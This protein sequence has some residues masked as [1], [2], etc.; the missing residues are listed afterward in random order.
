MSLAYIYSPL[1]NHSLVVIR[2]ELGFVGQN[3]TAQGR[4]QQF[5]Y[6]IRMNQAP[7]KFRVQCRDEV[8]KATL[9]GFLRKHQLKSVEGGSYAG[10]LRFFWLS[11]KID[12]LGYVKSVPGGATRFQPAP[13]LDF[14]LVLVKDLVFHQTNVTSSGASWT[15]V[16]SGEVT[17]VP[18]GGD[19]GTP[20]HWVDDDQGGHWAPG[21]PPLDLG[22]GGDQGP[23]IPGGPVPRTN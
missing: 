4:F 13:V 22:D 15:G 10:Q 17:L 3:Q 5:V 6:P 11:Q 1:G 23:S 18:P 21:P 19:T 14:E 9:Q 7:Y 8:E 16:Y 2:H 12:F 20:W